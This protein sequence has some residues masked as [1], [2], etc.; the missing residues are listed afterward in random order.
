MS[1][2]ASRSIIFED[3]Y[4][5][6]WIHLTIWCPLKARVSSSLVKFLRET[7]SPWK[8]TF[9]PPCTCY[10][11]LLPHC[12]V[13]VKSFF[14]LYRDY[15]C[16]HAICPPF[17]HHFVCVCVCVIILPHVTKLNQLLVLGSWHTLTMNI[18]FLI[19][20]DWTVLKLHREGSL[21]L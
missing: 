7:A 17:S 9:Y 15:S 3:Q 12:P 20:F 6:N 5:G 4:N 18:I 1:S 11:P 19:F 21:L 2:E 14:S 8:M 16:M 13:L 10:F